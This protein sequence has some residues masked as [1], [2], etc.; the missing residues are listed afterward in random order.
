[1]LLDV[2]DDLHPGPS[3]DMLMQKHAPLEKWTGADVLAVELED[4]KRDEHRRPARRGLRRDQAR[5]PQ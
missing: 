5:A 2:F 3:L 1:M 4:V